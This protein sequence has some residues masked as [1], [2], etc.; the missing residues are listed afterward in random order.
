[1]AK[2]YDLMMLVMIG[3][4]ERTE[5]EFESLFASA[6]LRLVRTI[7]TGSPLSIVEAAAA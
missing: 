6:G 7:D 3:G 4:R 1:M 5:A 2:F